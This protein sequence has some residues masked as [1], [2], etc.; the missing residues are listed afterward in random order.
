[1]RI[2][3]LGAGNGGQALSAHL[4]L[5]GHR[6]HIY[7]DRT[8]RANLEGIRNR[9]GIQLQ[10]TLEG[11]A[12][13]DLVTEDIGEALDGVGFI[14]LPVPS[15][16]QEPLIRSMIPYLREGNIVV[17]IPG[18]FGSLAIL[19][20]IRESG[21]AG[22]IALAETNTLPYACRQIEP[23]LVAV[24]GVKTSISL[25]ALPADQTPSLLDRLSPV[26]PIPLNPAKN[27][28][29]IG[30]SNANMIVHCPTILMNAGW[31]ESTGGDF[32]FYTEGM[33]PSVCRVME[34]MDRERMQ[35]GEMY[36]LDL[37]SV[38]EWLRRAY[39][40]KG[41]SLYQVLSTSPVYG[42]HGPD[43]PKS[44]DHRYLKEDVP[45]LLVPTV[46]L[47]EAGGIQA[48]VIKSI[49]RLAGAVLGSNI[50]TDGRN[51]DR[52]GLACMGVGQ[53]RQAV[54]KG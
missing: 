17:L 12:K 3:V 11:F 16:A 33:S 38:A 24:W 6:V 37:I 47:G 53:I 31:I 36:G 50:A 39:H 41:E 18:N 34:A 7:E 48:P 4:S 45:F 54:E 10:G 51:F 15:F 14:F 52:M 43:A 22:R 5:K 29:E 27:V 21:W 2:A 26:F 25:A 19:R 8:F 28:L 44:L 40:V 32:R 42:G 23:G 9:R 20:T 46:S 35:I 1:M 30:L 13:I 49:I